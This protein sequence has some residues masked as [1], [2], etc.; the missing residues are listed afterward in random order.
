MSSDRV[1]QFGPLSSNVYDCAKNLGVIFDSTLCF[2]KQISAVVKSSFFQLRS[3]A[4]IK[5]MLSKRDLETVI[6]AFITSR[7]D[8]CNSLYL[9]LPRTTVDGLQLVQNAAARLLTVSKKRE[10]ITPVLASL[11]WLPVKFRVDLNILLFAFKDLHGLALQYVCD[12]LTPTLLHDPFNHLVNFY[13]LLTPALRLKVTGLSQWL[14]LGF[15]IVFL[16]TLDLPLLFLC[17]NLL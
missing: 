4:R 3:A 16:F 6:H 2:D 8:Y 15:G 10:L 7:L 11:H 13:S 14:L 9:G 12:L 5:M 17:L 1:R